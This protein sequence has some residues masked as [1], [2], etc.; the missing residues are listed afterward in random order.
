EEGLP[1]WP[2]QL[3][4]ALQAGELLRRAGRFERAIELGPVE[5]E[6]GIHLAADLRLRRAA[7]ALEQLDAHALDARRLQQRGQR[8]RLE[9]EAERR[10]HD[11]EDPQPPAAGRRAGD[12]GPGYPRPPR[13]GATR[14]AGRNASRPT[15][16]DDGHRA[17]RARGRAPPL[18]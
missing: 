5:L 13:L 2:A 12:R 10:G 15:R 18:P 17:G 16:R 8:E 4:L 3:E 1:A 14:L 7:P 9:L 6:L 11:S